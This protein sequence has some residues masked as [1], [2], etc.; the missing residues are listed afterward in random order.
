MTVFDIND[1][2]EAK[3]LSG[4]LIAIGRGTFMLCNL[5]WSLDTLREKILKKTVKALMKHLSPSLW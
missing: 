4:F 1:V 5:L 2:A 3:Q